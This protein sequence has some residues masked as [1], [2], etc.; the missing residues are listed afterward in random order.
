MT[1]LSTSTYEFTNCLIFYYSFLLDI[2]LHIYLIFLII[3]CFC[4]FTDIHFSFNFHSIILLTLWILL[5]RMFS[6]FIHLSCIDAFILFY[7]ILFY[8]ILFYFIL[9]PTPINSSAIKFD[10]LREK[11][12]KNGCCGAAELIKLNSYRWDTVISIFSIFPNFIPLLSSPLFSFPSLAPL[13][14]CILIVSIL[15]VLSL[16]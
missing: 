13:L 11:I 9:V 8:F 3:A 12:N 5:H 16:I 10:F 4:L 6:F 15:S 2:S 1:W 14:N 7:F